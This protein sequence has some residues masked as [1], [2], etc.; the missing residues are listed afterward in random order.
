MVVREL[1]IDIFPK[2]QGNPIV[3]SLFSAINTANYSIFTRLMSRRSDLVKDDL[4]VVVDADANSAT[5]PGDFRG[6][7]DTP[8]V[9]GDTDYLSPLLDRDR[10]EARLL[11][12]AQPTHYEV[13]GLSFRVFP[14]PLIDTTIIGTYF[15]CP[16]NLSALADTIPYD[17]LLDQLFKD[18]VTRILLLGTSATVTAEY[19]AFVE[20]QLVQVLASRNGR[21]PRR[22]RGSYY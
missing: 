15:S 8:Q 4:P 3:T 2:L 22:V 20:E 7:V 18:A 6:L 14:V 11:D 19:E 1:I 21:K 10:A 12:S 5:L 13:R 17:G 9:S 16:T